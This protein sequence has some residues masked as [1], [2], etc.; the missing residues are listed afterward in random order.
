VQTARSQ[1]R[2]RRGS[3]QGGDTARPTAPLGE[4]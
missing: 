1:R 3:A 4:G 2:P